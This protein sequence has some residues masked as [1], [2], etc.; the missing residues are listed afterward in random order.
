MP[1]TYQIESSLVHKLIISIITAIVMIGGY[2]IVWA[3]VDARWKGELDSKMEQI[4]RYMIKLDD[5]IAKPCHDVACERISG[6]QKGS[7]GGH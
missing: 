6:L 4:Q 1:A 3:Y 7:E 5:H 2:M